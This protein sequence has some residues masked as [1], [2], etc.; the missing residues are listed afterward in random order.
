MLKPKT[1][2]GAA[3]TTSKVEPEV[4]LG[5]IIKYTAP[6]PEDTA[7][8][9]LNG[10]DAKTATVLKE[11]LG[12]RMVNMLFSE[13]PKLKSKAFNDLNKGI[14]KFDFDEIEKDER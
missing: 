5:P 14:G 2:P 10:A 12:T 7:I 11:V 6:R 13:Q 4:G 8:D 3:D 1:K 9:K